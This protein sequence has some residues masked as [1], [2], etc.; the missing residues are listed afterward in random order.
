MRPSRAPVACVM[1]DTDLLHPLGRAGVPC[2]VVTA[3]G[4]PSRYSRFTRQVLDWADPWEEPE[5]LVETLMRFAAAQSEPPVLFY[6]E[7][8]AV[9]LISRHRERLAQGYRFVIPSPTLVEDLVD[10]ARFQDLAARLDLPVPPARRLRP[11]AGPPP[12]DLDVRFPLILKPL[13]RIPVKWEPAA[14]FA[15]ARRLDSLEDLRELWPR[16]AAA[17]LEV[18]VQELITGPET[19]V[20]SY[21][22]YVDGDGLIVGEFTGRKIRTYP[23]EFGHSTALE[24][25]DASDVA[26][27]GRELVRRLQL[28]GV[29]KFDFKRAPDG[30]LYLFEINPRF[31]LWN[32]PGALAGVNLPLLVYRDLTGLRREPPARVRPG[33]RWCKMWSDR[34]AARDSGVPFRQWLP[35]ALRCEAKR[36]VAWDDPLPLLCGGIY[37]LLFDN[38]Y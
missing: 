30:R 2:V 1:G 19:Q 35:W 32:H 23:R 25:T 34:A 11:V 15:K 9:L 38:R 22:V 7:D 36:S 28:T 29:A 10:K 5:R 27:L 16:L 14:G 37:R 20:E 21:H 33:V 18:M 26:A 4:G 24:I 12:S 3:P 17:G 8:R 31:T 13:T 6:E